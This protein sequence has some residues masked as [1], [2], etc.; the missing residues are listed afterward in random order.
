MKLYIRES[1][2]MSESLD[3]TVEHYL[4]DNGFKWLNIA[5]LWVRQ[6]SR[7]DILNC[8]HMAQITINPGKNMAT[9][10]SVDDDE[11]ES[12]QKIYDELDVDMAVQ[13]A[14]QMLDEYVDN[15]NDFAQDMLDQG[16]SP[17]SIFMAWSGSLV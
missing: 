7:K 6:I 4:R 8:V 10:I 14:K 1:K 13:T 15:F 17:L 2:Y 12:R 16:Q 11:T 3:D 5:H 9:I